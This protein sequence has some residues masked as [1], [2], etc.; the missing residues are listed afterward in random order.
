PPCR[1][2]ATTRSARPGPCARPCRSCWPSRSLRTPSTRT[3][4][5]GSRRRPAAVPRLSNER[6]SWTPRNAENAPRGALLS[7]KLGDESVCR[8]IDLSLDRL[9]ATV[10][11]IHDVDDAA[12]IVERR[13]LDGDLALALAEVDPDPGVQPVG[14]P[15]GEVGQTRRHG[16]AA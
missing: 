6:P 1:S 11:G 13:E 9:V 12:Q 14:E 10:P 8:L 4:P 3:A 16:L 15:L 7:V 2:P 5:G